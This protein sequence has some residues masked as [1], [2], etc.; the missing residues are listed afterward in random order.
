[1]LTHIYPVGSSNS[2][3]SEFRY[4][5]VSDSRVLEGFLQPAGTEAAVSHNV[6]SNVIDRHSRRY[7]LI[8]ITRSLNLQHPPLDEP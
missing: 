6:Q 2:D 8:M 1:M 4:G 5:M 3:K 7:A